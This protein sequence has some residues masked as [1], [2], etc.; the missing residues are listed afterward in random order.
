M[1]WYEK[2]WVIILFLIFFFPVGLYLVWK[3]SEFN[4]KT[5][6]I[7]TAAILV[8]A[9]IGGGSN[10]QTPKTSNAISSKVEKLE[11]QYKPV[12]ESGKTYDIMT[13]DEGN[14]VVDMLDNWDKLSDNFKAE[15]QESKSIIENSKKAYDD[16]KAAEKEAEI[17]KEE[18]RASLIT[19]S[20]EIVKNNLKTPKSAKF[21]WS[22]DKY[23]ITECNS[24]T[25]GFKGYIVMGYVDAI[26]SFN[27]EIRSD[28][29]VQI[30][31]SDNMEKY[32]LI[33]CTIQAR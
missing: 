7:I 6:I 5:K 10:S 19:N 33:N 27:A 24:T 17:K 20:Q 12:L 14:I 13:D 21:P 32:K 9:L 25:D 30:E 29:A 2:T 18:L 11:E 3:H 31:I 26:N 8:I 1:K 15:Y 28:F 16:K 23:S 4:K 22:F